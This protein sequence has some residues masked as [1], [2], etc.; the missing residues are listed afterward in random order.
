MERIS[1]ADLFPNLFEQGVSLLEEPWK[2][3][4]L[5]YDSVK[6]VVSIIKQTR[7]KNVFEFGTFR[8]RTTMNIAL[9]LPKE[10]IVY[11][12]DLPSRVGRGVPMSEF[13][14]LYMIKPANIRR[15]LLQN[16]SDELLN[17]IVLLHGNSMR[18]NLKKFYGTMDVVFVDGGHT[19]GVVTSDTLNAMKMVRPGGIIIWDDY[20]GGH[21]PDVTT[22]IDSFG[23][24][25][26]LYFDPEVNLVFYRGEERVYE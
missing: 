2:F 17:K 11:S 4:D 3:G 13:E 21:C 12:L 20:A 10:G 24:E 7:A 14:S 26:K 25:N 22:F 8:G 1:A 5:A 9:N 23:L 19:L 6:I 18:V 16:I 15:E